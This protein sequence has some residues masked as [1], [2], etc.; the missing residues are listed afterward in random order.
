VIFFLIE[1]ALRAEGQGPRKAHFFSNAYFGS[2]S[3]LPD[4]L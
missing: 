3:E 2:S 4:V 1:I